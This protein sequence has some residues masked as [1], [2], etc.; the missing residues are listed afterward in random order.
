MNTSDDDS[1]SADNCEQTPANRSGDTPT[2]NRNIDA[3]DTSA[4]TTAHSHGNPTQLTN[5]EGI[6]NSLITT[7]KANPS[8]DPDNNN[9]HNNNSII[10]F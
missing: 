7:N 2:D 3:T 6:S 4:G 1:K 5:S 8:T 9:N 10:S